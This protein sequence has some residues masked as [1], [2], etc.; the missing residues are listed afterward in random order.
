MKLSKLLP[1]V[2][3]RLGLG[4]FLDHLI[5]SHANSP[6][7]V[8]GGAIV[9]VGLVQGITGVLLQQFYHPAPDANAAYNTVKFITDTAPWGRR[10][11]ATRIILRPSR[12]C[13]REQNEKRQ[14]NY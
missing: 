10:S 2:K 4:S 11:I 9:V 3:G 13:P 5:P 14:R 6:T 8:I 7:Y 12:I 1:W